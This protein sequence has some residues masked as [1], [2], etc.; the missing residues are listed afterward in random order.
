MTLTLGVGDDAAAATDD[1]GALPVLALPAGLAAAAGAEL[2]A[3]V[4]PLELLHPAVVNSA[5]AM[6]A[7]AA[8]TWRGD[9]KD[10]K[11][12]GDAWLGRV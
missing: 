3:S 10:R 11:A 6:S 9:R 2:A 1:A 4:E 8:L 5:Q 7:T 12:G